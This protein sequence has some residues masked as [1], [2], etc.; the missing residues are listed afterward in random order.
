[1]KKIQ[2]I[3]EIFNTKTILKYLVVWIQYLKIHP[4][5]Q[6]IQINFLLIKAKALYKEMRISS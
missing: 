5:N 2:I 6:V 4:K 1:M 3:K